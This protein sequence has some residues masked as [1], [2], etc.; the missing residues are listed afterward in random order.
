[1]T[2]TTTRRLLDHRGVADRSGPADHDL[3]R[4]LD[5]VSDCAVA[6]VQRKDYD[7]A[8]SFARVVMVQV[9]KDGARRVGDENNNNNYNYNYNNNNNNSALTKRSGC[10]YSFYSGKSTVRLWHV[11]F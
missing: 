7:R 9:L 1:M 3:D 4:G 2:G 5:C 8:V 6:H 10:N 11:K